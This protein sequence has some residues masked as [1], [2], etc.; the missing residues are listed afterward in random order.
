MKFVYVCIYVCMYVW[1]YVCMY[2]CMYVYE[3]ITLQNI[4]CL[5][6]KFNRPCSSSGHFLK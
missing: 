5:G 4:V 6:D 2:V 3:P 1:V